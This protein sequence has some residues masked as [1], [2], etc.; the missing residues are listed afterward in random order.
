MPVSEVHH[1]AMSVSDL[2]RA[3]TFYERALGYRRTLSARVGGPEMARSLAL[4]DDIA[5]SIQYLQGP[6]QIGQLELIQ[7][8]D[9]PGAPPPSGH[10]QLGTFLLSFQVPREELEALHAAV[11]ANGGTCIDRPARV[12]LE[13]YGHI[14]AFAARDPDGNLLEFV[15]LPSR[16]EV[17]AYREQQAAAAGAPQE[18]A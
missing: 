10:L 17:K 15:S 12:L 4:P 18:Q 14:H 6:S 16:A 7:W 9:G 13:N 1:V 11:E 5:G 2:E 8:D 3:A